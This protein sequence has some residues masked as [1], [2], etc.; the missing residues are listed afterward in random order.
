MRNAFHS[1]P[2]LTALN[3]ALA[4]GLFVVGTLAGIASFVPA[5]AMACLLIFP[6]LGL[7][8]SAFALW[9]LL[10]RKAA[11]MIPA[12]LLN[13]PAAILHVMALVGT[14]RVLLKP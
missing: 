13:G 14:L 2:L 5:W 4:A 9:R 1:L 10:D 7:V 3:I 6:P 8:V 12:L 11:V